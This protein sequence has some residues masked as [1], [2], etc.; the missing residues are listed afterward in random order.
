MS[1]TDNKMISKTSLSILSTIIL[2]L[3]FFYKINQD[4]V[5]TERLNNVLNG[6]LRAEQKVKIEQRTKVG[7]GF[8]GCQDGFLPVFAA[9]KELQLT[10]TGDR[11]HHDIV[12]NQEELEQLFN[13]FF[14]HGAAV[15]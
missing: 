13:Y 5:L 14:H 9:F 1:Q 4:F 6:L 7:V 12:H 15:E 8:G 2:A 11:V 10:P 3:A